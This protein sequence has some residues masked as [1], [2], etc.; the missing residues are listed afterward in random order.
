MV[1]RLG[2]SPLS[3]VFLV[4]DAEGAAYALKVL[5]P[6][7]AKDPRIL[8]RW[9]REG[10][11]LE[12]FSH[13]NL[14]RSFGAPEVEGRPALL[15]EY[16]DGSSLRERLREGPLGWEQAARF[17]VQIARALQYLHRQGAI[18][19][20]VKPH[21]VLIS[22]ERGAVLADL[23][24]VRREED[25]TMTRQG[26]A[27]GSPAYMSPEQAR[28]PSEVDEQ[29]DIY[30]LG[31]TLFHTLSGKPPFLGQGVGEVIH[32]VLHEEPEPMPD[33]V[34]P[35]LERVVLTAMA[36]DPER[37][38]ARAMDFGADL[39]RVLL[40]Y[41]PRLLTRYRRRR[42]IR[43]AS[44]VGMTAVLAVATLWWSPWNRT[45]DADLPREDSLAQGEQQPETDVALQPTPS[46]S[47]SDDSSLPEIDARPYFAAWHTP[48]QTRFQAA[49][50][51][52]HFRDALS[53]CQAIQR[54]RVPKDAP[55]GFLELRRDWV[56]R[57]ESKVRVAAERTAGQALDL[58]GEQ[59]SFARE[60]I[61]RGSF[62]DEAWS[63]A[64]LD[65][66]RRAGLRVTDLPLHPGAPDPVGRLQMSRVVL[67]NEA[68][69]ARLRLALNMVAVVR[70]NT[71]RLLRSGSFDE[72]RRR[73][74]RVDPVVFLHSQ[75]ARA[76]LARIEEL[77]A[78]DRRLRTRFRE[79]LGEQVQL[80]LR[81]GGMLQGRLVP[82]EN[83]V[84]HAVDYLGQTQVH[85]D[86]LDLD[87]SFVVPWLLSR[88]EP[89]L[90]AQLTW[91]QEDLPRAINF[92][93]QAFSA[94]LPAEWQ[95]TFW[96]EQWRLERQA[97][98][99]SE[100][101][102][103]GENRTDV[104]PAQ[105]AEAT[106]GL[107]E[108]QT[109]DRSTSGEEPPLVQALRRR[110][111]EA[112]VQLAGDRVVL[113]LPPVEMHGMWNLDL[114]QELRGWK[115]V[116]WRLAWTLDPQQQA[117]QSFTWLDDIVLKQAGAAPPQMFVAGRRYPGF[118][119]QPGLGLQVLAWDGEQ[120]TLDGLPVGP[121][122][123]TPS[124]LARFLAA[125]PEG[126]VV[127]EIS[128]TFATR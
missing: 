120:I 108:G 111:P 66:W 32:R 88:E 6:S 10:Q 110:L 33:H 25:P 80:R 115:M 74:D 94:D 16:V 93:D 122:S 76:D 56:N 112:S 60:A 95:P 39:G 92:M 117:P 7:V 77:V 15:L 28:D 119:M 98:G 46:T 21:N 78:L 34:P 22:Q 124:T 99:L 113:Q 89:W 73:W 27:L 105:V 70:A 50:E 82:E 83:G 102:L 65:Q 103:H 18:H 114:R 107:A 3:L 123:P 116:E 4:E 55:L 17:G 59:M 53:E 8:E 41:P 20:D 90:V 121:W 68:E 13:P 36:K 23:G 86:L 37:R 118:G 48:Y 72:A 128:L 52:N 64:V 54:A 79:L 57:S 91:C 31:A 47:S 19:R 84:G 63:A 104:E 29:A 126:L 45:S 125:C 5:R 14:V 96:V 51:A 38:Y 85:V 40:G 30:S 106:P 58:L 9:R 69:Q 62:D 1:R 2:E 101:G 44:L 87:P 109:H 49:L 61:D 75:D 12:E 35:M 26:A 43:S 71:A 11:L 81:S 127:E 42:R 24:L 97:G 67:G 100:T